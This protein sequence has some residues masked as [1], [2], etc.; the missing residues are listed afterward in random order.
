MCNSRFVLAILMRESSGVTT[1]PCGDAGKSCGLMQV[2][3]PNVP[4][5]YSHPCANAT[6]TQMIDCGTV[7]CA[8]PYEG[9]ANLHDCLTRYGGSYGAAARCYNSGSVADPADWT[10]GAGNPSYVQDIA[11][12][13]LGY[14][15]VVWVPM[16]K[17]CGF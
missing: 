8:P 9:G 12:I 15:A 1:T 16:D 11:N 6:I 5:C 14:D 2:Q 4:S 3:G 10:K 17:Q 13:L 7:G